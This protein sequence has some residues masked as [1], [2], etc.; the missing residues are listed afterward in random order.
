S[1]QKLAEARHGPLTH[2]FC[3]PYLAM[4]SLSEGFKI[5]LF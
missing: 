2:W 4:D 5:L 3:S 1:S